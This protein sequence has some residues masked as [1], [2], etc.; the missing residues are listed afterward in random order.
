MPFSEKKLHEFYSEV[1]ESE[2]LSVLDTS[3]LPAHI[4]IIMDGN[5]RWAE[6]Q[7][8]SRSKGHAAGVD[9]LRETITACVRLGIPVLSAYAFSTENWKR[10]K[11][12]VDFLMQLFADT[13]I[14]ELPL[15]HQEEVKLKL[16]GDLSEL[17]KKTQD[18]F[19]KGLRET[20]QYGNMTLVL[21]V[22]Y[23]G[24]AEIVRATKRIVEQGYKPEVLTEDLFAQNLYTEGLPDPDLLIRTSGEMRLSN[25]LLFQLAYA[26]FYLTDTLWPDF[27]RSDLLSALLAYQKRNRR[28]GKAK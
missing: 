13:L 7:G 27:S 9:A 22:N 2:R 18:T 24:R 17:P 8:L 1:G 25:F 26:E 11:K 6:K 21:A 4:A 14:K 12:E 15:F 3:A 10:P 28:F 23:G 5:G 20:A 16:I 19:Q